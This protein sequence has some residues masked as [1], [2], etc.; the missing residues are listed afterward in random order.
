M[1]RVEKEELVLS[2][3]EQAIAEVLGENPRAQE[4]HLM[5]TTLEQRRDGMQRERERTKDPAEQTRLQA[6]IQELDKQIKVLRQEEGITQFVENSVRV[7]LHQ[8]SGDEFDE[9]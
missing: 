3:E 8:A 2:E 6:K 5:R 9:E 7:T 4:L 1:R